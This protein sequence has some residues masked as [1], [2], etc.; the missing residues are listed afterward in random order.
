MLCG[1]CEGFKYVISSR[2]LMDAGKKIELISR[3]T[4]EVLTP[5]ELK[6][7]VD[8]GTPLKHYIGFEISGHVHIGTGVA[9]GLKISD[10]QKAGVKCSM[11][12]AT[13][14]AWI[15]NKLGGNLDTIRKGAA[16]FK[17]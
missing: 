9:S 16:Y 12:L 7:L 13:Y 10:F 14:H 2:N 8:A 3:N 1:E 15:N 6:G 5:D 17:E 4:D 11:Y